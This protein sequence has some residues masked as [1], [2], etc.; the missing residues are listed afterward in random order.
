MDEPSPL[1]LT[2]AETAI[3]MRL[4]EADDEGDA[5]G[6]ACRAVDHL[7]QTGRLRAIKVG[8][9]N[10][11]W[12]SE[13]EQFCRRETEWQELSVGGKDENE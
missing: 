11:F 6:R 1:L 3:A 9:F 12:W 7:V 8:R 4:C 5:L 10:R 2:R 13:I